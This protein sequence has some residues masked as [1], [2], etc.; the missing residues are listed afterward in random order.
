MSQSRV[1]HTTLVVQE[2]DVFPI[3]VM[4]ATTAVMYLTKKHAVICSFKTV[5]KHNIKR[6]LVKIKY[7]SFIM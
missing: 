2:D 3:V 5:A 7:D 6:N 4:D 1:L